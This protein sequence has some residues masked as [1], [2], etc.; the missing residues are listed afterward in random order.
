M[1]HMLPATGRVVAGPRHETIILPD[2]EDRN[3]RPELSRTQARAPSIE[4]QS[5]SNETYMWTNHVTSS[6]EVR[7]V[8]NTITG[9]DMHHS[10]GLPL[11]HGRGVARPWGAGRPPELL[12][13]TVYERM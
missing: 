3:S 12:L 8:A 6:H 1:L 4:N 5:E 9:W 11:G 10:I 13:R 7:F 2:A